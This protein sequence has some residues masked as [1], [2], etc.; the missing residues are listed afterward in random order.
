MKDPYATF[1]P[2]G[3]MGSRD[4]DPRKL[5]GGTIREIAM[6]ITG[7]KFIRTRSM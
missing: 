6:E 1:E 7:N 2:G 4:R 5:I 3:K